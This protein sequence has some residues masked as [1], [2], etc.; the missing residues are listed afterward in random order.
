MPDRAVATGLEHESNGRDGA[1]SRSINMAFVRPTFSFGNLNDYHLRISPKIYAYI[2][3]REDNPDIA[4]Y[5]GNVD[6]NIAFG[7]P[8]GIQAFTITIKHACHH[9]TGRARQPFRDRIAQL[10]VNA[11]VVAGRTLASAAVG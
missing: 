6:L 8:D 9:I 1:Q 11:A 3:S 4:R 7:K 5:R 10:R 2:G